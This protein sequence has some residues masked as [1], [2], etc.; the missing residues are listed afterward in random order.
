M[1]AEMVNW[2]SA[3][4]VQSLDSNLDRQTGRGRGE[5]HLVVCKVVVGAA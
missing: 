2:A 3:Y 4:F 1:V 5:L